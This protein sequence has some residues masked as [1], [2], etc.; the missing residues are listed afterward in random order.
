MRGE[1]DEDF[2]EITLQGKLE[3]EQ[4]IFLVDKI[5]AVNKI[6]LSSEY[7]NLE[8]DHLSV[9]D[10]RTVDTISDLLTLLCDRIRDGGNDACLEID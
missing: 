7:K 6:L 4:I 5:F 2:F 9:L 8:I 3:E 1:L 10:L